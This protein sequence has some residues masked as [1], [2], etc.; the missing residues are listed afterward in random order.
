MYVVFVLY[1]LFFFYYENLNVFFLLFCS[2]LGQKS[3]V[4]NR[5]SIDR[6]LNRS[7]LISTGKRDELRNDARRAYSQY[8]LCSSDNLLHD[9][10]SQGFAVT[11]HGYDIGHIMINY[12]PI[13]QMFSYT[14]LFTNDYESIFIKESKLKCFITGT[15][16]KSSK[17]RDFIL[18]DPNEINS[19][20]NMTWW[21]DPS[22]LYEHLKELIE[23]MNY[24]QELN[25][26]TKISKNHFYQTY[27][28]DQYIYSQEQQEK[29]WIHNNN[30]IHL[31]TTN[32][33]R[34]KSTIIYTPYL[35][36]WISP[37]TKNIYLNYTFFKQLKKENLEFNEPI[38]SYPTI[39]QI[40]TTKTLQL[41]DY[42]IKKV[43]KNLTLYRSETILKPILFN[44][45][46][47]KHPNINLNDE[48]IYLGS[49][50]SSGLNSTIY[51][52]SWLYFHTLSLYWRLMGNG[53][54]ALNCLFQSHLLSPLN[55][56]DLTYLSMAL[57]IYNSQMNYNEAI[58][59][60]Y[61]SL[62]IDSNSLLLTHFTL[63]NLM[64]RK[65]Y[66]DYA[67]QWYQSTLYLKSDFEPAKQRLRAIQC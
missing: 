60:L 39:E 49:V 6:W 65:G 52:N 56:Q 24:E 15:G 31:T 25:N 9:E 42:I 5:S 36:T 21:R 37:Q 51:N 7:C 46:F 34:N 50:L 23:I 18:I 29:Y 64:A 59:L 16:R 30:N 3:L 53:T 58:Y 11:N 32:D 12:D 33:C 62:D 47:E 61:Q 13:K 17:C 8:G 22:T 43:Q 40:N 2:H 19:K 38:C 55:V 63:G 14:F 26:Q 41:I 4:D 27:L 45:L 20:H 44:L 28:S 1:I 57:I 10:C 67:E 54:Q 35:S 66:L 48:K